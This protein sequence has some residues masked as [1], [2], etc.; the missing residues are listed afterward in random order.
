MRAR[1]FQFFRSAISFLPTLAVLGVLAVLAVVGHF[2]EWKFSEALKLWP[3]Q[4]SPGSPAS[5]AQEHARPDSSDASGVRFPSLEAVEKSGIKTAA[6]T[7]RAMTQV[8]V[9]NGS[10]EYDRTRMAHLATRAPGTVW[11]VYR[12]WGEPVRK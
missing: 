2:T 10:I 5:P 8:V 9:A 12:R 4:D 3:S 7:K 11:K 1:I 6:V